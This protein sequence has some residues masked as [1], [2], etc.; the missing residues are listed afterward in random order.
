MSNITGK[1]GLKAIRIEKECGE[2]SS[3]HFQGFGLLTQAPEIRGYRGAY[4]KIKSID[5]EAGKGVF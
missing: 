1:I 4:A 3:P 2:E 5:K